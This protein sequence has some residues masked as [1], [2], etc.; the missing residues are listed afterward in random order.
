MGWNREADLYGICEGQGISNIVCLKEL[1]ELH[2]TYGA[3]LGELVGVVSTTL[4]NLAHSPGTS[5]FFDDIGFNV[6]QWIDDPKSAPEED[7]IPLAPLSFPLV[8]LLSLSHF[9]ITCEVLCKAPGEVRDAFKGF[10]GHSQGVIVAAAIARSTDWQSFYDNSRVAVEILFWIGLVC[11][12]QIPFSSPPSKTVKEC[13]DFGEGTPSP[14]LSTRGLRQNTMQK[15]LDEINRHLSKDE[16]LYISLINTRDNLVIGGAPNS[17]HSLSV[18]LRGI[19]ATEGLDQSKV[20]FNQ[21][22]PFIHHQFLPMSSPFHCPHSEKVTPYILQKL[23]PLSFCGEDFGIAVYHTRTGEDLRKYGKRDVIERLVWMVTTDLVDW[24]SVTKVSKRSVL[25]D[26]G[27]GRLRSLTQKSTEGTGVQVIVASEL[28]SSTYRPDG[29]VGSFLSHIPTNPLDWGETFR[30]RLRIDSS[31]THV[32]E[33][34]MTRLFGVPP[35]M[36]AGMTPTT[37]PWDFV[38]SIMRAGYHAEMAGGGYH[39]AKAFE[40]AIVKLSQHIPPTSGITCNIIYSDPKAVQW[41]IPLI[42]NLVRRGYPIEGLTIGA[43]VPSAEIAKGYIETL[44]LKHIS[45][46][47]GSTDAIKQVISIAKTHPHFPIGLQWTGGRGG[48]HHSF[49]DFHIPILETY[50]QIRQCSNVVLIAGSGFG[51]ADDTYPY[52][53]GEW[54]TSMGYPR[55]PFDGVLLASRIMVAKEAHTSPQA[56]ALIAEAAGVEDSEWHTSYTEP[57]G[58][59]VTV[60]SEWGQPIHKLA[61]R[62]GLLW[63]EFEQRFFSIAD[64]SVRLAELHKNRSWVIERLN[65]DF[66][67][68]WFGVNTTGKPLDLEDMTY[69]EVMWRLVQLMYVQRQ[70]RWID[71]SY[72]AF[73]YDFA[74]RSCER[75]EGS[76]PLDNSLECPNIFLTDFLRAYPDSVTELLHPE[77]IS[78]FLG[79]CGRRGQKPVNFIPR[80]DDNFETWF[81]KDSL[82]QAE[83]IEAVPNRDAQRV[84]ILQGPVAARFSKVVDEPVQAIL[85][86]ISTS[87]IGAL[88]KEGMFESMDGVPLDELKPVKAPSGTEKSLVVENTA[89]RK[90][91]Q[92]PMHGELPDADSFREILLQDM[93]RDASGWASASVTEKSVRKN[94]LNCPNPIRSAIV[95]THGH[96]IS[97]EYGEDGKVAGLIMSESSSSR[98]QPTEVLRVA[99][100]KDDSINVTLF[101]NREPF[102]SKHAK[103]QFQ[104]NYSSKITLSKLSERMFDRNQN[105]KRFYAQLWLERG[106][107]EVHVTNIHHRFSELTKTGQ[108]YCTFGYIYSNRVGSSREATTLP[109]C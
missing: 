34:R 88:R 44:G 3:L 43:G 90:T 18:R 67:K 31:G 82:W 7:I 51:G 65:K 80:L 61:T 11:H 77:D 74:T 62:A 2:S 8:G 59:I 86:S 40:T 39:S 20:I 84:C 63:N 68:P 76:M 104:F 13:L 69:F 36:V 55:M 91:Y 75:L 92:F 22:K 21:R 30:P 60:K 85:D 6:R 28:V 35:V 101:K 72:K 73:V 4:D 70:R 99:Q 79:L 32:L 17:L 64:R 49:E 78:Y 5:G 45:F 97:I 29:K 53:I 16:Q 54:S 52:L 27:P 25:V 41:Q 58:G 71:V 57:T 37:V 109:T 93:L 95:P 56:K 1:R 50:G 47:P 48:G 81:K 15:F 103:L 46:K 83:D 107:S 94:Q 23:R 87:H 108:C 33:T 98:A 24:P 9:C 12:N 105:I 89:K 10:T 26:F 19:K 38:S 96:N 42:E 14:M 102:P 106:R 100:D 66:Q